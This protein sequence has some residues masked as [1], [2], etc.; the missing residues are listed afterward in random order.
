MDHEQ[1]LQQNR[2][3]LQRGVVGNVDDTGDVQTVDVNT[4]DDVGRSLVEVHQPYGLSSLP[5]DDQPLTMVMSIG[6]DQGH[7]MALHL[8]SAYRFGKLGKGEVALWD[9]GGNRLHLKVGGNVDLLAAA[10]LQLASA[11]MTLAAKQ[12]VG[13]SAGTTMAITAQGGMTISCPAGI[14]IEGP[15]T[16]TNPVTFDQPVTFES[17]VTIAGNLTVGG[18][19]TGTGRVR[20]TL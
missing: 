20:G 12:T 10:L 14:T 4:G 18:I 8:W 11:T 1:L 3:M 15:V 6:G 13:I 7:Q 17:N 5:P 19:V 9:W 2:G 16:F